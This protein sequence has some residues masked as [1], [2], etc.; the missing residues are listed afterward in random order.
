MNKFYR[1]KTLVQACAIAMIAGGVISYGPKVLAATAAGTQ[2]KNLATV[3]YEDAAG[4]VY[5]A[6]SNEAIVTV[7]QVYTATLGVDSDATAAPGQ[8]VYLPYVLTNTGNGVDTFDLSAANGITGGDNVDSANITIY[9]DVNGNGVPDAGEQAISSVTL[10]ANVDNVANLVVAVEVPAAATAGQTLGVTLTAQAQEGTGTAVAASVTDLSTGGGRDTFNST[11]ESLITVT[12]DAVLVTTKSSVHDIANSEISYTITVRN[13]GNRPATNVVIFDGLPENTTLESAGV[14]GLLATNNDTLVTADIL[15]E[16]DLLLDLNADGDIADADEATL[17][18]DLNTDGDSSDTAVAGL[19]AVDAELPSQSSVTLTFTVSYDPD[20]ITGGGV[21]ENVG[22]AAGDTDGD[23]V[24]DSLAPSNVRQD[25]VPSD[26]GVTIEDTGTA[27]AAGV[28]DGG[29]DD[30]VAGGD[31]FV[32]QIATGGTVVFTNV[33]TNTGNSDDIFELTVNPGNFPVG[34]V[35]TF[36]DDSGVVQLTDSNGSGVDSGVIASNASKTIVVKAALPASASGPAPAPATEYEA[37]VTAVSANDPAATKAS[38]SV[39]NSL[40]TIIDAEADIH[41]AANGGIGTNENLLVTPYAS[42]VSVTGTVGTSVNIP[43]FVDNESGGSDSYLLTAG[44]SWDG[45][46]LGGLPA[47]WSVEFFESD[48]AGGPTGAAITATPVLPAGQLDYPIIAVVSI[49]ADAA[50]AVED[51]AIDNNGDATAD[52]LDGNGDGDGDYP[53]FFQIVSPTTGATDIVLDSVDVDSLRQLSLVTPGSNQAE[54]GGTAAYGH[55]LT[56]NGNVDEVVEIDSSNS[57]SGWSSTV[58]ID[59]DG[60]G[61]ADTEIGNLVAGPITVLQPDNVAIVIEVTDTDNDGNP[62]ITLAP[63]QIVPLSATVFAPANAAAGQTD[64]LTLSATNTDTAAG[65]PSV[66]VTDQ[67]TVI[68]GQVRLTKTVAVDEG[69]NGSLESGFAA[70][71]TTAV[72]PGDC[73]VWRV[74]AENQGTTTA[75]NVTINDAVPAFS[76]FEAG[77]LRYCLSSGCQ[78]ELGVVTDG[79]GDDAGNIVANNIVFYVGTGASPSTGEG[80]VLVAGE[81]ATAQFS[82]RVQ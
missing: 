34:T 17:G 14:S 70:V 44:S 1:R 13:N 80:G 11:N 65:A 43:L 24:A 67:T 62:E 56:N 25:I 39:A 16:T 51:V 41:N 49:P 8:I 38:D 3:T 78:I 74:V 81:Q 63:G 23:G 33:I 68:S 21:I 72:E 79:P 47:G 26:F 7:A 52:T 5:S 29:D 60:D 77:T 31:Q 73:A 45:T 36:F 54:A 28:N 27:A 53:V 22:Y 75:S 37:T 6:Q 30:A 61:V 55:T 10:N 35:F 12:G 4:N 2:I 9:N 40:G 82:V 69:C 48:G 20:V 59:T 32:D 66:T 18:I 15:D 57:Q 42:V 50:L 76:V 71:Q 58:N 19:Y 46:T 64:V